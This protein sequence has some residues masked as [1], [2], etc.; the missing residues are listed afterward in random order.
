MII[1]QISAEIFQKTAYWV[2]RHARPL[3]AAR[4]AYH[5]E[6]GAKDQVLKLLEVYQ[7]EDGGFGHGIEPDFW[8]PLSSPMATWAAVDILL[9]IDVNPDQPIVQKLLAYLVNTPQV[10]P[11]VWPT[12]IPEHNQYPHAPWWH[13]HEEAQKDWAFNPS[14]QLAACL[15]IWSNQESEAGKL[16]WLSLKHAVDHLLQCTEMDKHQLHNYQQM[17]RMLKPVQ[18][19]FEE[20][21]GLS[22]S[23]VHDK[24]L[25]L[26]GNCIDRDVESWAEGY[27]DLPLDF[28]DNRE[29]P[30]YTSMEDLI[31]QNLELILQQQSEEGIWDISWE[32]SDY[33]EQFAVARRYWNG[34][35]AVQRYRLLQSF[36]LLHKR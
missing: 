33:P 17:C 36:G 27:K 34:I 32:W 28:I 18:V 6:D 23:K 35:L 19:I 13:W 25:E 7:N 3:E 11:G 2:K 15:I 8:L 21:I 4:W 31:T 1:V 26:I 29:H 30:L 9:E 5:F 16:G 14:V 10:E 22:L 20:Q 24:V 12:V